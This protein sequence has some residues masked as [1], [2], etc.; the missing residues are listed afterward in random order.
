MRHDQSYLVLL[1]VQEMISTFGEGM[2]E[3]NKEVGSA[4]IPD[5]QDQTRNQ[6]HWIRHSLK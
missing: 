4:G 5:E 1:N 3:K 2:E 6:H